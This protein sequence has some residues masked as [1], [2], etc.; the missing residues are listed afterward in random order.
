MGFNLLPHIADRKAFAQRRSASIIR[1][2]RLSISTLMKLT[3]G[4]KSVWLTIVLISLV[5]CTSRTTSPNAE[6]PQ[7]AYPM[8]SVAR[9]IQGHGYRAGKRLVLP[10]TT[11]EIS[12]FRMRSKRV[13]AFR[14]EQP[15]P[16][17]NETYYC[18]FS[19]SEETFDSNEDARQRLAQLHDPWPD[20]PVEDQYTRVLRDGFRVGSTVYIL[21]TDA[22]IFL[23]EIQRLTKILAAATEGASLD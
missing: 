16:N 10:P 12:K 14:A 22:A 5:G 21:Q 19:F 6:P 15:L 9:E 11:W 7:D 18:R 2:L 3:P 20:G 23:N 8:S 1:R 17:E 4:P 13:V